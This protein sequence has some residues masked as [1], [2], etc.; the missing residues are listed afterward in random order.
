MFYLDSEQENQL[1]AMDENGKDFKVLEVEF[2]DE[3][4]EVT[5]ERDKW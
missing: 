2:R 1:D 5:N 3:E 4:T